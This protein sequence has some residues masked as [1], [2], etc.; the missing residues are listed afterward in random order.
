MNQNDPD[1]IE[2]GIGTELRI[3]RPELYAA[4]ENAGHSDTTAREGYYIT[5]E[6]TVAMAICKMLR[7]E[8][9]RGELFQPGECVDVEVKYGH[10]Y[11]RFRINS[12][13]DLVRLPCNPIKTTG[14]N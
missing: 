9:H 8:C 2:V 3:T 12:A 11:G 14:T 6:V 1:R 5:V 13:G 4:I 10:Y 7:N